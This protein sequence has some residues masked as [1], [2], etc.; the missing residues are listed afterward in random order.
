MIKY[1]KFKY[2]VRDH[3]NRP[4]SIIRGRGKNVQ[5]EVDKIILRFFK[6]KRKWEMKTFHLYFL[7]LKL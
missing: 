3:K 2:N 6:T 5:I 7:L 4:N 1:L